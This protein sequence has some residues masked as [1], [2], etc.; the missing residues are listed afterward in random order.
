MCLLSAHRT[1]R[2]EIPVYPQRPLW[3]AWIVCAQQAALT[4]VPKLQRAYCVLDYTVT[5]DGLRKLF[6]CPRQFYF[7][8]RGTTP[9]VTLCFSHT[10]ISACKQT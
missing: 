8:I 2:V 6:L 7:N 9:E 1:V 10:C 3:P 5:K 4:Q